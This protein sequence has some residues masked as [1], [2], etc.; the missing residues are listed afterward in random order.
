MRAKKRGQMKISFGMIFSLML[1]VFFIVFAIYAIKNFLSW[2]NTAIVGTFLDSFQGDVNKIWKSSQGDQEKEYLL[3]KKIEYICFTDFSS[4]IKGSKKN[5][6]SELEFGYHGKENLIF[7]PLGSTGIDS[8]KI[9]NINLNKITKKKNPYCIKNI[10]GKLK[11]K[12]K[13][14]FGEALVVVEN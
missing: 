5:L 7:Y 11:L 13:K 6:Y 3:P 14:E 2:N 12:I 4:S 9:S 8:K 1:I 10:K